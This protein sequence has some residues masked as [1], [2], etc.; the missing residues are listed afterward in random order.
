MSA[1][2]PYLDLAG[3]T[4]RTVMP[5]SDVTV[6]EDETPGKVVAFI[7][8]HQAWIDGRMRK[9]YL[10]PFNANGAT[11]P[12]LVCKWLTTL[13]TPDVYRARGVNPGQDDQ[14]ARLDALA[15]E[16]RTEIREAA[17][18]VDGLFDLP[19]RDDLSASAIVAPGPLFASEQSPYAWMNRQRGPGRREDNR[20]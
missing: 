10:T 20:R 9:R 19:L 17:D 6:V 16:A 1:P 2:T 18:S 3:F 7:A 14:V 12:E 15:D 13:V 8:Q 5:S 4:T 11:C